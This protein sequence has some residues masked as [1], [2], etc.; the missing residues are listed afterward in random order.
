MLETY[1]KCS[2]FMEENMRPGAQ[3]LAFELKYEYIVHRSTNMSW[4]GGLR[5]GKLPGN[6]LLMCCWFPWRMESRSLIYTQ[7]TTIP[8]S[9]IQESSSRMWTWACLPPR[10]QAKWAVAVSAWVWGLLVSEFHFVV[11]SFQIAS[12]QSAKAWKNWKHMLARVKRLLLA[13]WLLIPV[14][15]VTA[16]MVG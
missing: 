7:R 15:R 11:E 16:G 14:E 13:S 8:T 4:G 12:A 3:R 6:R 5:L 1:T 9:D 10:N 2:Y